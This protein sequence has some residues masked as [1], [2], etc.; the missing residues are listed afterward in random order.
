MMPGNHDYEDDYN[1]LHMKWRE[2]D[3]TGMANDPRMKSM[4]V[5]LEY[6]IEDVVGVRRKEDGFVPTYK[7]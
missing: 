7:G 5:D 1:P 6:W 2:R 4:F 3:C